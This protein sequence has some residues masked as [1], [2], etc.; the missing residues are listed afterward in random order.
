ML[1]LFYDLLAFPAAEQV[2]QLALGQTQGHK[3]VQ[4]REVFGVPGNS[5]AS[6]AVPGD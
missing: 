6:H 3:G 4:V 2:K 1:V 5:T